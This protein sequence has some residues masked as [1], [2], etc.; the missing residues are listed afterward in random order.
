GASH[1]G[2]CRA[3]R[4]TSRRGQQDLLSVQAQYTTG[5][6][7]G[8]GTLLGGW[9]GALF[10]DWAFA[11]QITSGS[12]M[13]LTPIYLTAVRGTGVTGSVRPHYTGAAVYAAPAGVFLNPAAYEAP[14]AGQWGG[15]GRKCT[16]GPA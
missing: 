10:K 15:A 8:G 1:G 13:P 2:A 6:G 3:D 16:D 14:A 4:R 12:G 11:T 9:R 7:I 5:M